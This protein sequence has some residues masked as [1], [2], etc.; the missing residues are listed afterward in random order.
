LDTLSN[1]TGA[2]GCFIK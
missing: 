1:E 2:P